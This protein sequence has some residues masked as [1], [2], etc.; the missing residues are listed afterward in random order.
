MTNLETQIYN[1]DEDN[2]IGAKVIVSADNGQ[3][4][5]SIQITNQTDFDELVDKLDALDESYVEF[6]EGSSLAGNS[7][8]SI[9]ENTDES[10]LINATLFS[11]HD[12]SYYAKSSHTH[13]KTSIA[14][15]YNYDINLSKYN[16]DINNKVTVTVKVT[17][18]NNNGVKTSVGIYKDGSPW[19]N[20]IT[21]NNGI[22]STSFTPTNEGLVTFAVNNQKIQL[23]VNQAPETWKTL[24]SD[25]HYVLENKG[26]RCRLRI[27]WESAH[28]KNTWS[29]PK[30][31]TH[32]KYLPVMPVNGYQT[33][34]GV[35]YYLNNNGKLF[36]KH[37]DTEGN[38]TLEMMLEW[39]I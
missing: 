38:Y 6:E 12:S 39:A 34:N 33:N 37:L 36:M 35:V 4:I 15:L 9:L 20:G 30:T 25:D 10:A 21:N 5:D 2:V 16:V 3:T 14:D 27:T 28:L 8:D 26:D 19:V 7:L 1:R 17:D 31:F 24:Y 29:N 23:L 13:N 32:T 22:F 11:G 18:M